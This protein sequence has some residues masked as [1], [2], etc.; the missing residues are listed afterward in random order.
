VFVVDKSGSAQTSLVLAQPGVSLTHPDFEKLMVMNAVLGG[1]FTSRVNLNLRERHGYAYG[2]SSAV[3]SS[4]GVGL[5]TLQASTQTEFTGASIREL[6]NEVAAIQNAPVSAEELELAKDSLSRSLPAGFATGSASAGAIGGLY[7]SDLPP[8]YYQKL[9]AEIAEID[10]EDVQAVARTHLRP[11]EMKIIAV[12][13]RAQ[14]DAQLAELSL[15]PI[16]YRNP[17]GAPAT[18]D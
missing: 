7:L 8:D 9:P 5:I 16:A 3:S 14:I 10:I 1:G 18:T 17:D 13:D 15:G 4:R 12:G 11:Q 6:L 2:A